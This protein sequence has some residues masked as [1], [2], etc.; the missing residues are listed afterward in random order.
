MRLTVALLCLPLMAGCSQPG[1]ID[2]GDVG[3]P[4]PLL[5]MEQL[6]SSESPQLDAEAA[7]AL[8]AR[9]AAL[10]ARAAAAG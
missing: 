10:R 7:E 2:T 1:F 9:G 4:P 8:T 6:L 3:P 5:P